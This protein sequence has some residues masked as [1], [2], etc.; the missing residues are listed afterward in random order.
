M[1]ML[2]QLT[3]HLRLNSGG[4]M[5]ILGLGTYMLLEDRLYK[6][7]DYALFAGYRH[8][9]TAHS[10]GNEKYIGTALRDRWDDAS[11][12][13]SMGQKVK[14]KDLF[15]TTKV[16]SVYL[17]PNDV[18]IC[19]EKSLDDL[20]L[21]YVDMLLIHNPWGLKN[22]G[23]GDLKPLNSQGERELELHDLTKTWKAMESLV[24]A[25]KARNIG[26]SNFN[27]RQIERILSVS[28]I[29]PSNLQSEM[30]IY[31]QQT[32]LKQFCDS[33]N[34]VMTSYSTFGSPKRP[35]SLTEEPS[36]LEEP[37]VLEIA[38][39]IRRTPAQV[40]LR[41]MIQR[42]IVVIPKSQTQERIIEN[43]KIFDFSLSQADM[44]KLGSLHKNVKYFPFTWAKKHP[45]FFENEPF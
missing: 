23:D 13:P 44:D 39:R 38:D 27:V 9:D 4:R 33:K 7:L 43:S 29:P 37:V 15:I 36:P 31:L 6:A 28:Q 35:N 22:R 19:L 11:T 32:K 16:P 8:I 34:I 20:K 14:R 42:D 2:N 25:G 12:T 41:N 17:G 40:L 21:T 10:Y 18:S 24:K 30:H 3:S 45:E 26:V 5:P 1:S